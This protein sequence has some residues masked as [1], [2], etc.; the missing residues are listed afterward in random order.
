MK[1]I[2]NN[3]LKIILIICMIIGS[4]LA[5]LDKS[6]IGNSS[7]RINNIPSEITSDDFSIESIPSDSLSLLDASNYIIQ[8]A[9]IN[10]FAITSVSYSSTML[11]ETKDSLIVIGHGFFNSQNQFYIGKYSEIQI[12][13]FASN[14]DFV[15]LLSCYSSNI[16]LNNE[17]HLTFPNE[18]DIISAI[19][20]LFTLLE[21]EKIAE[22][23]PIENRKLFDLHPGVG[24]GSED[25]VSTT[26]FTD[27][28]YAYTYH[29]LTGQYTYWSLRSKTAIYSINAFLRTYQNH[30]VYVIGSGEFTFHTEKSYF[31]GLL[32]TTSIRYEYHKFYCRVWTKYEGGKLYTCINNFI[33]DDSYMENNPS[34]WKM[35]NEE[36]A[37]LFN[38]NSI[39]AYYTSLIK[40]ALVIAGFGVSL[41]LTGLGFAVSRKSLAAVL[42]KIAGIAIT[43]GLIA[44]AGL[45]IVII[46]LYCLIIMYDD[47]NKRQG[48]LV[49]IRV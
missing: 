48:Y 39:D 18:I 21:W 7:N 23:T 35:S 27:D 14:K 22:F 33:M 5:S 10:N 31:Y 1:K 12:Q 2:E 44:A 17:I 46:C 36:A 43:P 3:Y 45:L 13:S 42:F 30:R 49:A 9:I 8:H 38:I 29:P 11:I 28:F 19:N 6:S 37:N 41:F 15:A 26:F 24:G 20:E 16:K 32:K 34:L 25:Y 40:T 4:N 47:W